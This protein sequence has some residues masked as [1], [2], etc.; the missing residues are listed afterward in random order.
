MV[1]FHV[2]FPGILGFLRL[3]KNSV[4]ALNLSNLK[5]TYLKKDSIL[6]FCIHTA[7]L[8]PPEEL[9]L[10]ATSV[11]RGSHQLFEIFSVMYMIKFI[12][13]Y[14]LFCTNGKSE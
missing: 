9:E 10:L 3:A 2:A 6:F 14:A 7:V 13:I 11:T 1:W 5:A 12:L 4:A 8:W